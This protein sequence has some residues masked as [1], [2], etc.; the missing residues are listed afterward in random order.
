M[1]AQSDFI[2]ELLFA[3]EDASLDFKR[4]QYVFEGADRVTKSELLKDI[5]AFVN[6]FRRTDAYILIG[7]EENRAGRSK[8]VG[9]QEQLDDAKLQQFVNSKTQLP[10]TFAYSKGKLPPVLIESCHPF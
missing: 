2:E 3:E 7:V 5:L 9:V 8:V 6:A 10:V 1:T 4:Q